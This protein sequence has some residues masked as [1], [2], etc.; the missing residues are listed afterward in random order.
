LAGAIREAEEA[1]RPCRLATARLPIGRQYCVNRRVLVN[2]ELGCLSIIYNRG[3]RADLAAGCVDARD[4]LSDFLRTGFNT[5]DPTYAD[6]GP[7]DSITVPESGIALPDALPLD[8]PVDQNLDLLHFTTREGEPIGTVVR[9]ACHPIIFR[10]SRTRQYSADYPGVLARHLTRATGAPILFLNG[11]CGNVKPIIAAYG[12]AETERFGTALATA[13]LKALDD[14]EPRALA[15]GGYIRHEESFPVSQDMI[16]V[17]ESAVQQAEGDLQRARKAAESPVV[18][19]KAVD[20]YM[21]A[22]AGHYYGISQETVDLPFSVFGFNET[23][24]V[25]FPGEIF[26]EHALAVSARFPGKQV[27]TAA[28]TETNV[29]GYVPVEPAFAHGGYEVSCA[30]LG[31]GAGERMVDIVSILA[32]RYYDTPDDYRDGA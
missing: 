16:G 19:K 32:A 9:F 29:P 27:V 24:L 28:L 18:V 11:P 8:G 31:P 10:G 12:E 21:R 4:Q 25:T 5:Y 26:A 3:T 22:W 20:R 17:T 15:R 23:V 13:A 30:T 6:I 7:D 14:A 2:D 1:A